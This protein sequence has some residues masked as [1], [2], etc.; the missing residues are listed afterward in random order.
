MVI[1]ISRPLYLRGK[2]ART[3]VRRGWVGRKV[4]WEF[5]WR[6]KSLFLPGSSVTIPKKPYRFQLKNYWFSLKFVTW[7]NWMYLV[8]EHLF[9]K[10]KNTQ[11][12]WNICDGKGKFGTGMLLK[13]AMHCFWT[14]FGKELYTFQNNYQLDDTYGLSFI[15]GLVVLHSTCFELQG[16]HHQE[17]TFL[18]YRQ[19]LAY[20]VIFCCIAPV[21][22][23]REQNT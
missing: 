2:A 13:L 16:A 7:E 20:C 14:L 18:L 17:F 12:G 22:L 6:Q 9:L 8:T 1:L 10:N 23:R 21:P 4:S 3:T 11:G 5:W 15:S 19:P